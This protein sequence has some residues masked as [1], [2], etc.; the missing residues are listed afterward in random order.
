MP[1]DVSFE[2]GPM[3]NDISSERGPMPCGGGRHSQSMTTLVANAMAK[4][5]VLK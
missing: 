3:P 4:N 5:A 1:Y 2:R